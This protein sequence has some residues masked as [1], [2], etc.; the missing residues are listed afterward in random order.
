M[1]ISSPPSP[2]PLISPALREQH[3]ESRS[4]AATLPKAT[5]A[6]NDRRTWNRG[7]QRE[8]ELDLLRQMEL[9]MSEEE[10]HADREEEMEFSDGKKERHSQEAQDRGQRITW[11]DLQ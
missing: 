9:Y 11:G 5:R 7:Q 3:P 8:R 6:G 1:P 10:L 2:L 4:D